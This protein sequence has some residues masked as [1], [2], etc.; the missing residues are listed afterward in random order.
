MK[1]EFIE[2]FLKAA[3]SVLETLIGD[4]AERG[5]LSMR[6][7][8]FTTQ[9]VTIMAGV[10]GQ[11]EGI[12]LYG[13]SLVTAQ[14]IASAMMGEEVVQ[15][16]EMAW[17]AVSELGNMITGNAANLLYEA[18]FKCDITPPSV[19]QGMNVQISTR[20]PTLVVPMQTSFG[21][22]EINVALA[23]SAMRKAA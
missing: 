13:M 1:V 2:P 15:M 19:I 3:F 4:R 16:N 17:S 23:E 12:A 11:V 8:T 14:K 5:T 6:A 22:M 10:N 7:N 9:Q 18:G 21:R 20:V